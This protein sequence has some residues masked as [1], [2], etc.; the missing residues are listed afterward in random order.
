M[1]I[2]ELENAYNFLHGP[3]MGKTEK[4]PNQP[5]LERLQQMG[6]AVNSH[7][8]KYSMIPFS[9]FNNSEVDNLFKAQ[10]K[11]PFLFKDH[12]NGVTGTKFSPIPKNSQPS[13]FF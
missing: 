4:S 11:I 8:F 7:E 3:A 13:L 12:I 2:D 10:S 1:G 6:T 5:K 9:E